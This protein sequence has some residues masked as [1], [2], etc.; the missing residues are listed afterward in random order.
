M[1]EDSKQHKSPY[2]S[3]RVPHYTTLWKASW[4]IGSSSLNWQVKI[5]MRQ[6][7]PVDCWVPFLGLTSPTVVLQESNHCAGTKKVMFM[8]Y[9]T[10]LFRQMSLWFGQKVHLRLSWPYTENYVDG[11]TN[12]LM[13]FQHA[14]TH[15][16][17]DSVIGFASSLPKQASSVLRPIL[18]DPLWALISSYIHKIYGLPFSVWFLGGP[19]PKQIWSCH[20]SWNWEASAQEGRKG[21]QWGVSGHL[22]SGA[23]TNMCWMLVRLR[24]PFLSNTQTNQ[25]RKH[26]GRFG[27]T[28][29]INRLRVSSPGSKTSC[30]WVIISKLRQQSTHSK[31]QWTNIWRHRIIRFI[32]F[33]IFTGILYHRILYPDNHA[34]W[35]WSD[36]GFPSSCH[37]CNNFGA[38]NA[39]EQGGPFENQTLCI[40]RWPDYYGK[41]T[42]RR[43][44]LPGYL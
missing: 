9:S 33:T 5:N 37:I 19:N 43:Q 39:S 32:S 10:C 2:K 35:F 25:E 30:T 18:I 23:A 7:H 28:I 44:P 36:S 11:W 42:K 6:G 22:K 14:G 34:Q 16:S 27:W 13:M 8:S 17:V 15:I 12:I 4:C 41:L 1:G 29:L 38:A 21:A 40:V 26:W 24:I 3:H 31:K 20:Q